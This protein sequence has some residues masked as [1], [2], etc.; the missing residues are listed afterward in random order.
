MLLLKNALSIL[1]D[2]E[3]NPCAVSLGALNQKTGL[4]DDLSCT[5][6]IA[7]VLRR[8]YPTW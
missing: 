2:E 4:Y 3:V 7:N 5:T 1:F 6:K 8:Q